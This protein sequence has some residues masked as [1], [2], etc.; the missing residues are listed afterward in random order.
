MKLDQ[1]I[2]I[3]LLWQERNTKKPVDLD[4]AAAVYTEVGGLMDVVCFNNTNYLGYAITHSGDQRDGSK[5]G[6]D[7]SVTLD[8]AALPPYVHYVLVIVSFCS[9][10]QNLK[11]LEECRLTIESAGFEY[12]FKELFKRTQKTF[13]PIALR[14][15]GPQG[16]FALVRVDETCESVGIANMF[17]PCDHVLSNLIE[18]AL[19]AER[20]HQNVDPT[21]LKK[22]QAVIIGSSGKMGDGEVGNKVGFGLGWDCRHK[23][24]DLD[25]HCY[26]FDTKGGHEHIY[27]NHKESRDGAI[28]LSG[29]NL[30]GEGS[31]DDETICVDLGRL[32]MNIC[33]LV[34]VVQIYTSGRTFKD[35]EGEFVRL[36]DEKGKTLVRYELDDS[37]RFKSKNAGI[38]CVLRRMGRAWRFEATSKAIEKSKVNPERILKAI[39]QH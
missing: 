24:D 38:F 16:E 11:D 15:Q 27:F 8:F 33:K 12:N 39:E 19:W 4:L 32:D 30:T 2:K 36:K 18:P 9:D 37:K 13:I 7:E 17:E 22:E 1:K 5:K 3:D 26:A 23:G 31:G 28:Q 6:S 20:P 10:H 29:D 35:V 34:F 21:R 25:A 14:R